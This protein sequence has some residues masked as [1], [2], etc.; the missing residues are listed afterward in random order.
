MKKILLTFILVF[1]CL[2]LLPSCGSFFGNEVELVITSIETDLMENGETKVVITYADETIQPTVFYLPKGKDGISGNGISK[3]T[4][5]PSEDGKSTQVTISFT[6]E[7]KDVVFSVPNGV[8]VVG[9]EEGIDPD[10][11]ER[12]MYFVLSN[13]DTSDWIYLP[14]GDSGNGIKKWNVTTNSDKSVEIV[15]EFTDETMEPLRINIPSPQQ[16]VGISKIE[17]FE[18]KGKYVMLITY[19][20]S[21]IANPH[22]QRVE[23]NKPAE[24]NKWLR[25]SDKPDNSYGDDGDYFY[26]LGHNDIY[27]KQSGS[28][29]LM[30]NFDDMETLY[31]ITFNLNDSTDAPA[32]LE[33]GYDEISYKVKRSNYFSTSTGLKLPT[34]TRDGYTFVGW[35]TQP[36]ITA[37]AGQFTD[38]TPVFD[39]MTLYAIWEKNS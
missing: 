15:F 21:T 36:V 35:Y 6:T 34:A 1:S 17:G 12:Y 29:I 33:K 23:F 22:T 8:S 37:T 19:S 20:D 32:R 13:G 4:H 26:D 28:W 7:M 38:I 14:K 39:S 9:T 2:G 27:F 3:I 5:G 11:N 16:G 18:E 24:P 10:T 31:V 30:V 25:G